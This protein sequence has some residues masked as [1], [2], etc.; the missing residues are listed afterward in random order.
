VFKF[1]VI[2]ILAFSLRSLRFNN[3]LNGDLMNKQLFGGALDLSAITEYIHKNTIISDRINWLLVPKII[4]V[5]LVVKN[6]SVHNY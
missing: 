4:I 3:F 5:A 1:K 6:S 2:L